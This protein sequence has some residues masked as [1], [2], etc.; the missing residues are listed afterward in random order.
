MKLI[1]RKRRALLLL[2]FSLAI[3]V[4]W[5][6]EGALRWHSEQLNERLIQAVELSDYQNVNRLL[7]M[8]ANPNSRWHKPRSFWHSMGDLWRKKPEGNE[9]LMGTCLMGACQAGN[10]QITAL[11]LDFGADINAVDGDNASALIYAVREQQKDCA[12]LL[13]LRGAYLDACDNADQNVLIWTIMVN[14]PD[15]CN[16]ALIHGANRHLKDS[17]GETPLDYAQKAGKLEFVR[18]LQ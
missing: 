8:G 6:Y 5:G 9:V 15:I 4:L 18:I 10:T 3:C 13:I 14:W 17:H 11:L 7:T 2:S 12:S 16:L 1:L